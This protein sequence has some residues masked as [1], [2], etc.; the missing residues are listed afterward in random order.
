[1][2][3]FRESRPRG[4]AA[5]AVLAMMFAVDPLLAQQPVY[6]SNQQDRGDTR[7]TLEV[8]DQPI[9]DVI[10]HIAEASGINIILGQGIDEKVT[11]TLK[12][13]PWRVALDIVAEKAGCSLVQKA[14]NVI[15]VVQPQPVTFNFTGA[16]IKVVIDGWKK[17][18]EPNT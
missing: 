18:L 1:M 11:L 3:P 7:V 10:K 15:Q 6:G 5:L 14:A 4:A 8:K 12:Q 2:A 13:V 9:E 17:A 16:D